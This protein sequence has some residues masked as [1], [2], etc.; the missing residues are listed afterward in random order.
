MPNKHALKKAFIT[1]VIGTFVLS[2]IIGILAVVLGSYGTILAK[3]QLSTIAIGIFSV[4]GLANLRNIE[5]DINGYRIFA[6]LSITFSFIA[7]LFTMSL[8]W[9]SLQHTP[10]KPTLVFMVLAISTAHA[11]LLLAARK[12]ANLLGIFVTATLCCIAFVAGFLIYLIISENGSLGQMFYRVLA[13][14][15]ILDVLGSVVT[16]I[17]SRFV[18]NDNQSSQPGSNMT[19]SN[20]S[21]L[22]N[23]NQTQ[24]IEPQ[25]TIAPVQ[26]TNQ[27]V[28]PEQTEHEQ[29]P[30]Q[31][32]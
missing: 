20:Y 24:A 25:A 21:T 11:S 8:I 12:K 6:W 32:E 9:I 16:P 3:T 26:G 17:L 27:T 28:S 14:F 22:P 15:V 30:Q 18:Y 31:H 2:A 10:W 13:I 23:T 7:T 4:T 1:A 29:P 19:P 5:S